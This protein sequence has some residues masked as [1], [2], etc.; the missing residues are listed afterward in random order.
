MAAIPLHPIRSLHRPLPALCFASGVEPEKADA[1]RKAVDRQWSILAP[2]KDDVILHD[3]GFSNPTLF[4]AGFAFRGWVAHACDTLTDPPAP[5]PLDD[6]GWKRTPA[7]W[8]RNSR[9]PRLRR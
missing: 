7:A 4:Y 8:C 3:A 6:T 1:A 5:P 9:K 2:E